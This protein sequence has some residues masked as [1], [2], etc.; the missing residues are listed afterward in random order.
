MYS[1]NE[2]NRFYVYTHSIDKRKGAESLCGIVRNNSMAPLSG[3][4]F[5]FANNSRRL[6]KLLHWE[7]GGFVIYY[8]RLEC[9][10]FS[11]TLFKVSDVSFKEMRWDENVKLMVGINLSSK[12]SKRYKL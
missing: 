3:I 8:K 10:R 5:L 6:L 2:T 12:R 7:R 9:G 1:L 4:V 11:P